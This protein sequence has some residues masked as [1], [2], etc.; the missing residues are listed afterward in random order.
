METVKYLKLA[1]VGLAIYGIHLIEPF[2]ATI[3]SSATTHAS[4]IQFFAKL[5]EA[6]EM[7]LGVSFFSFG[8]DK[9]HLLC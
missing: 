6:L 1:L 3:K 9:V 4:L 7:T 2:I 8:S 5:K